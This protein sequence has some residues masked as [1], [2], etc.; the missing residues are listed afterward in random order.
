MLLVQ[1]VT[2][3]LVSIICI[4]E[5]TIFS[6]RFRTVLK[7]LGDINQVSTESQVKRIVWITVTGNL[8]FFTRAVLEIIF[9]T[10]LALYWHQNGTVAE[11]FSHATWDAYILLKH[12]SEIAILSLMLYILQNRFANGSEG[13][14]ENLNVSDHGYKAVPDTDLHDSNA[15]AEVASPSTLSV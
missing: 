4:Y 11:A 14:G 1:T 9:A 15:D 12:W 13:T 5:I 3:A 7:T 10:L 6:H 8:F 2:L